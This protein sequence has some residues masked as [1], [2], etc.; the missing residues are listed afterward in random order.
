LCVPR[1]Y[2]SPPS[3]ECPPACLC[4]RGLSRFSPTDAAPQRDAGIATIQHKKWPRSWRCLG[5]RGDRGRCS[6]GRARLI[7]R[8]TGSAGSTSPV[9]FRDFDLH[10]RGRFQRPASGGRAVANGAANATSGVSALRASIPCR[11]RPRGVRLRRTHYLSLAIQAITV[12]ARST[13]QAACSAALRPHRRNG[14]TVAARRDAPIGVGTRNVP[15]DFALASGAD[16][17][18]NNGDQ[19]RKRRRPPLR[20][21]QEPTP[22][23]SLHPASEHPTDFANSSPTG[24]LF[25]ALAAVCK[26][27][28]HYLA[29]RS[30]SLLH[31]RRP[32]CYAPQHMLSRP[33]RTINGAT[34]NL[35]TNSAPR[36]APR[37][38]TI[39]P[40]DRCPHCNS[41]RLIKKGTRKK[42]FEDVPLYRCRACGRTFAPGPRAIRNKTAFTLYDRGNTSA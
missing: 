30:P 17:T 31:I 19:A 28:A 26:S 23:P 32:A 24:V 4:R 34:I 2:R 14:V 29:G 6:W 27:V 7:S 16:R 37:R 13:P 11:K 33:G 42:K 36:A 22:Q 39:K 8:R 5:D 25:F 15:Q 20:Q 10:Q 12:L 1:A 41:K 21:A 9:S 3:R 38:S 18:R 35:S 40:P